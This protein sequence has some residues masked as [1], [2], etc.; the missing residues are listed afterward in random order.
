MTHICGSKLPTNGSDNGLS[1]G[2]RQASIWTYAGEFLIWQLG[3][4]FS[5][6]LI[7]INTFSFK[8]MH[9]KMSSGKWRPICL[10]LNMLTLQVLLPCTHSTSYKISLMLLFVCFPLFWGDW[11][12]MSV[13]I[14]DLGYVSANQTSLFNGISPEVSGVNT[15]VH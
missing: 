5:K 1:P 2:R 14:I 7:E 11:I 13:V 15:H 12:K 8:K 6:I 4:N 3:T 9:L 10:G